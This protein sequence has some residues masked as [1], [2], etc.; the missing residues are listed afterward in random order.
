[1]KIKKKT[2]EAELFDP[3]KLCD[4]MVNVGASANLAE[5]VCS[6]VEE[7]IDSGAS[8]EKI[9]TTTRKYLAEFDAGMAAVYGLDRGLSALGPSGFLFEQYVGALL[10]ELG[11]TVKTNVFVPG[12]GAVHEIDVW[13]EK[14]NLVFII[15]AK[16]RNDYKRK[17]HI[18]QVMY[19]DARLGD[20]RRR[21]QHDGDTREYYGWV[22]TNTRFTDNAMSYVA[23]RDIQLMGWDYPKYINLMKIAYEKKL[24][25][26]TVIPSM[27]RTSLKM[28]SEK[29]I[30]LVKELMNYSAEELQKMFGVSMTQAKKIE[31]DILQMM[32]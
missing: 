19:A 28:L 21:A 11:Y 25:P 15:E 9:Y 18:D 4:S 31:N 24:Y 13:A 22:I 16:Y 32:F 23:F 5:Q 10:R 12:E 30:V 26:V 29:G 20:I 1:M 6:I 17:T 8:T 3:Q 27:T 14:G 2:G 7:S